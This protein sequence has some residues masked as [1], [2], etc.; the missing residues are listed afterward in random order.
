MTSARTAS[1]RSSVA[2][3]SPSGIGDDDAA[4]AAGQRRRLDAIL[5][6]AAA[7]RVD[8]HRL[9]GGE[10]VGE[11][12][13]VRRLLAVAGHERARDDRAGRV[14][15]DAVRARRQVDLARRRAAAARRHPGVAAAALE[16][17]VLDHGERRARLLRRAVEQV[18]ALLDVGDRGERH[19]P[20]RRDDQQHRDEAR[21]QAH[22]SRG[23]RSA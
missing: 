21:A 10:V 23:A 18:G 11:R 7:L 12:G 1:S 3:T 17:L 4:G 19:Q 5:R 15:H 6:L 13:R 16:Q 14:A 9:T 22:H 8:G 2:S 20:E